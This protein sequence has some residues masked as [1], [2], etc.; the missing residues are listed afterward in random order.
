MK[1]LVKFFVIEN[2]R[3]EVEEEERY[4]I[5]LCATPLPT[6]YIPYCVELGH[7]SDR[8]YSYLAKPGKTGGRIVPWVYK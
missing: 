8:D 4:R 7:V 6:F 2:Y 1:F 3:E 5:Y